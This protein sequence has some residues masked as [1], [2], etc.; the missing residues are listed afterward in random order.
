MLYPEPDSPDSEYSIGSYHHTIPLACYPAIWILT[1]SIPLS[2]Y[3]PVPFYDSPAVP[4][5][6]YQTIPLTP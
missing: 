4:L 1:P 2:H 5:F 3:A 6:D